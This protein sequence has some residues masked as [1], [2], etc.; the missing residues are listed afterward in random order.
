MT[1]TVRPSLKAQAPTGLRTF[2]ISGFGTGL[3]FYDF[4]IYGLAAAIV[5]PTVFFPGFDRSVG[6]LVAF[7]AFGSGFVARPLGGIVFGHFGDRIGRR[8]MLTLLIMGGSTFLIGCLPSYD[9]VGVAAPVML[10][11]LRLGSAGIGIGSLIGTGVFTAITLLP[12]EQLQAWAGARRSGWVAC[13]SWSVWWP[14]TACRTRSHA[15]NA[16][17]A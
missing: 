11:V 15:P 9:T 4:I 13:W 14:A 10:V 6:T 16:R 3:E 17:P 8:T 2:F 7:A 12:E 1:E 5:F